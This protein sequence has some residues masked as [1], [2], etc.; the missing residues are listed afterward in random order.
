VDFISAPGTSPD[1]V[2]RPG[3]PIALVTN[4]CFF[5]FDRAQGRFRLTSVHPGH[6]V[7]EVLE[8]TGFDFDRPAEVPVTPQ[9]TPETLRIMREVVGPQLAEIYPQFAARV[10][11]VPIRQV[12]AAG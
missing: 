5:T 6:T 7:E 1:N 4:R 9:P 2:Y 12:A 8:H 11:G 10:F 3:G